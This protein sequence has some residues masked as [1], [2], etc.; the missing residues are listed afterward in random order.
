MIVI[1]NGL[2]TVNGLVVGSVEEYALPVK[3]GIIC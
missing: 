2:I 3:E 1:V